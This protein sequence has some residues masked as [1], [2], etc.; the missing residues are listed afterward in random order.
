MFF[1][2]LIFLFVI[3][4]ITK[5][6]YLPTITKVIGTDKITSDLDGDGKTDSLYISEENNKYYLMANINNKNIYLTPDKNLNTLGVKSKTNP[7]L[8]TLVDMNRDKIPE[9]CIQGWENK[10]SIQHI[11]TYK[12]NDFIDLF[13]NSNTI[14]GFINLHNNK[15]PITFTGDISKNSINL[16]GYYFP[17]NEKKL[18]LFQQET[19]FVGKDTVYSFIKLIEE[20]TPYNDNIPSS[21]SSDL[22]TS[23]DYSSVSKLSNLNRHY[24][25]KNCTFMDNKYNEDGIL[26]E[27]KWNLNFNGVSNTNKDDIKSFN[28]EILITKGNSNET[29]YKYK[30][31]SIILK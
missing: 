4:K 17:N 5:N 24:T 14:L 18:A 10:K 31:S 9:I 11:F 25:F 30:L 12:N 29:N 13:Y 22:L 27:V 8:V 28:I 21:I 16:N 2:L 15:T 19:S 7:L 6:I 23:G 26:E 20:L 1:S 3:F